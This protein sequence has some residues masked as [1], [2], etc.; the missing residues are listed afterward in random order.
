MRKW[1]YWLILSAVWVFVTILNAR[2]G[3]S[4]VSV[5]FN[6]AVAAVY[7]GLGT[8]Q[9]FCDRRGEKG[10][11]VMKYICI[12]TLIAVAAALGVLLML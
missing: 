6:G 11:N 12:G 8:A 10:R 3:R 5:G 9:F 7:A 4:A 2:D 1:W